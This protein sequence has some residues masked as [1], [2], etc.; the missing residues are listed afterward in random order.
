MSET[1]E[2]FR[3]FFRPNK[4][5][6]VFS[7]LE[8]VQ[9]CISL[10]E[11]LYKQSE[12][13]LFVQAKDDLRIVGYKNAFSQVILNIIKNAEDILMEKE[14]HPKRIKITL[15]R[16][17]IYPTKMARVS[18]VDNAGG[19]VFDD[20]Q[21]VFEPYFTTKH[22]SVGTGIGLYMSKQIIEKQM[23]GRI[24]VMNSLWYCETDRKTYTGAM[25]IITVPIKNE[26]EIDE[27]EQ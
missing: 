13:G 11:T 23:N 3:G 15:E 16:I 14:I 25:F 21:K 20:I 4:T 27:G 6:E 26:N 10:V 7:V 24:E 5:K 19:I 12:I 18:I 1:I 22:K 17:E 8:S 2:D 9:D